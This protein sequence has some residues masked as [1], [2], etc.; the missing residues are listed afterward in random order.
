MP[1]RP[2]PLE[3]RA[4]KGNPRNRPMP[5][6]PERIA[7]APQMPATLSKAAR[8]LWPYYCGL[9][10]RRGQLAVDSA[11]ALALLCETSAEVQELRDD[12]DAK[13]RFQTVTTTSGDS[14]ERIRPTYRALMDA[15]RRQLAL[16]TEFGLTDAS[17]GKVDTGVP[18]PTVDPEGEDEAAA[19]GLN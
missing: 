2:T 19:Y 10:R 13:G 15:S 16:L 5:K 3:Q 18:N 11:P 8:K 17:R 9:L 7:G 1:R 14:M 6:A 4:A 12:I